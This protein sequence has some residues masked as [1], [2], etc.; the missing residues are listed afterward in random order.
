MKVI[1]F[2]AAMTLATVPVMSGF[3]QSAYGRE[4]GET[5][6]QGTSPTVRT[7]FNLFDEDR[8]GNL[9]LDL[10]PENDN[11]GVF[12]G[13]IENYQIGFGRLLVDEKGKVV[14][15]SSGFALFEIPFT[16]EEKLFDVG[17]LQAELIPTYDGLEI[18]EYTISGTKKDGSLAQI[19]QRIFD[20]CN[21]NFDKKRA[22]NDLSYILEKS[23]LDGTI[24]TAAGPR[25]PQD[26]VGGILYKTGVA[27][28]RTTVP[29]PSVSVPEPSAT[30]GALAV[31]SAGLLLKRKMK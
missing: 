9:I 25:V 14:R 22:V 6:D 1:Q 3:M 17:N 16:P 30:L 31:L 5:Y 18:I 27:V 23:L 28:R 11:V 29:E 8:G 20:P 7:E 13:A 26:I 24:A 15:D 10:K 4:T 19:N 12:F 2:L 21:C